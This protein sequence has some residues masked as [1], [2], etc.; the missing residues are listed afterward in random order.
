MRKQKSEESNIQ[1]DGKS[2]KIIRIKAKFTVHG[3]RFLRLYQKTF[4]GTVLGMM[5]KVLPMREMADTFGLVNKRQVPRR[6][7]KPYFSPE[8]KVAL[9]FLK[10]YTQLSARDS[11]A[12]GRSSS[13]L[14][15]PTC[16]TASSAST[17]TP[18]QGR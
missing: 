18:R 16:R 5:K 14:R 15:R 10:M 4:E 8:G 11:I 6:G 3:V 2:T 13:T 17:A 9:V 1:R 12:R 7:A